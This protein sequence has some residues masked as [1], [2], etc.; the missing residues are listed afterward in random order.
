ML[1]LSNFE[2][3]FDTSPDYVR[4]AGLLH[5]FALVVLFNTSLPIW[6][7]CGLGFIISVSVLKIVRRP[8]HLHP[9]AKLIGYPTGWVLQLHTG[10]TIEYKK[11]HV[12]FDGGLF[13]VLQLTADIKKKK[14]LIFNDQI[15]QAQHRMLQVITKVQCS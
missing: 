5:G 3:I 11:A 6:A 12:C 13:I 1:P 9:Y 10:K 15:T 14:L 2:I 7:G 4:I 8:N